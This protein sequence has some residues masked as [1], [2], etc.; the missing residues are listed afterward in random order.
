[1]SINENIHC[2]WNVYLSIIR[3]GIWWNAYWDKIKPGMPSLLYHWY[4]QV[5]ALQRSRKKAKTFVFYPPF[6]SQLD[7]IIIPKH[8]QSGTRNSSNKSQT[9]E[10]SHIKDMCC[11]FVYVKEKQFLRFRC[12]RIHVRFSNNGA[13]KPIHFTCGFSTTI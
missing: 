8:L 5:V 10:N 9:W 12:G 1:M 13:D 7:R 3:C 6:I 11:A 4:Q 2:I